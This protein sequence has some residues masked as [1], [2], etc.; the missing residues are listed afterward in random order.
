MTSC[1]NSK[2]IAYFND[3]GR[4]G[5]LDSIGYIQ[6]VLIQAGDILQ[7][8]ISTINRDVAAMFNPVTNISPNPLAQGYLVARDGSIEL[9]MIGKVPVRGKTTEQ[10]NYDLKVEL[11]KSLKNIFVSTRLLNFRVSVLGDVARPGN[12]TI[13]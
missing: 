13:K 12:Y 11:E 9:P 6:P 2:R 3:I 5:N 7:I 10:I 8:T 4:A 1:T